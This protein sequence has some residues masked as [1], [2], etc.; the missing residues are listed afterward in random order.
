MTGNIF[1]DACNPKVEPRCKQCNRR[2][3]ARD[4]DALICIPCGGRNRIVSYRTNP[5]EMMAAI[6]KRYGNIANN[7]GDI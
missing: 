1:E 2:I 6:E 5:A 3:V 7:Q 4:D